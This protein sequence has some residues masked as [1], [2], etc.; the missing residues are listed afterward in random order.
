MR[1][2]T[3]QIANAPLLIELA[4]VMLL[5]DLQETD[6]VLLPAAISRV[7]LTAFLAMSSMCPT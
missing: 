2:V 1:I 3:D 5:L 7:L 6:D 4:V